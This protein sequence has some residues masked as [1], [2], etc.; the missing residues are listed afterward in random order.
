M[1]IEIEVYVF[2]HSERF[3]LTE[4]SEKQTQIS[5]AGMKP[6]QLFSNKSFYLFRYCF[7]VHVKNI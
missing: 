6:Y 3:T 4:I 2:L 7:S 5:V 1:Y